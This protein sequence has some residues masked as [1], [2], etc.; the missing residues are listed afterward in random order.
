MPTM[1]CSLFSTRCM[2]VVHISYHS[3][4]SYK[5]I[6]SFSIIVYCIYKS[7]C[8]LCSSWKESEWCWRLKARRQP[9]AAG[10]IKINVTTPLSRKYNYDAT[11]D[12][13]ID[14]RTVELDDV[15]P[16]IERLQKI[17]KAVCS[18]S[19]HRQAWMHE[20]KFMRVDGDTLSHNPSMSQQSLMLILDVRMQWAS[21]HQMLCKS[22]HPLISFQLIDVRACTQLLWHHWLLCI[23]KQGP[24][25]PQT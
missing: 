4:G 22:Q 10:T 24:S 20:I 18:S 7:N 12:N 3:F 25:C 17:I 2:H 14:K 11:A 1:G 16:T 8:S 15:L 9:C 21:T 23:K 5:G 19:Q 6:V 13:E